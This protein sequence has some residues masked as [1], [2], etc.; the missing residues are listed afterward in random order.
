MPSALLRAAWPTKTLRPT[1]STSPPS[2]VPG[3]R[4]DS[5]ARWDFNASATAAPSPRRDSAPG[6][7]ITA[8]SSN[9]TATSSTNTASGIACC[10]GSATTVQ[11]SARKASR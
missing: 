7:V 8:I 6:R 1:R 4:I 10:A 3:A 2:I 5:S 11:P 9:T